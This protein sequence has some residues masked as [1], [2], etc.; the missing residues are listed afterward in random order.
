M[1]SLILPQHLRL[2]Q[3]RNELYEAAKLN[4][5]SDE[6]QEKLR[7]RFNDSVRV[8]WHPVS[9]KHYLSVRSRSTGAYDPLRAWVDD[10]GTP[11]P[12]DE[13]GIN[14]IRAR[15]VFNAELDREDGEVD[16]A[17]RDGKEA[18]AKKELDETREAVVD[19]KHQLHAG[20][21][22]KRYTK[23]VSDP[24]YSYPGQTKKG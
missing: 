12:L 23:W 6:F 15:M 3:R 24:T 17:L 20:L 1:G 19:N 2:E 21:D 7:Q 16:R 5:P 4:Q 11:L 18:E 10:E 9:R 22:G 13:H 14:Y 8:F